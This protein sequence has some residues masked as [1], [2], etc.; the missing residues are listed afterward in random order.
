M[1]TTQKIL[2]G[3]LILAVVFMGYFLFAPHKAKLGDATVSNYPTWY[4]N[5]IV[6]GPQ[7]TLLTQATF[8][9]CNFTGQ[10]SM[11]SLSTTT[12]SCA[13]AGVQSGDK[14]FI[15]QAAMG[16]STPIIAAFASTTNGFITGII[17]N[18]SGGTYQPATSSVSNVQYLDLR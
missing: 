11:A 7:N 13:A 18:L 6:I 16:S 2:N 17:T 14:V 10:S 12:L 4:Y 8:G 9:T 5:G 1:T 3:I 15:E